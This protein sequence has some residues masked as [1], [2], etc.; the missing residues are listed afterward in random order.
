MVAGI[1][2]YLAATGLDVAQE[3]RKG[4]LVLSSAMDHLL[5]G[6]FD[7][8]RMLGMFARAVDQALSDGY[9]GLWGTGDMNWELGGEES[10]EKLLAYECGLELLLRSQPALSGICQYHQ[11]TLSEDSV[12]VALLTHRSVFINETLSRVNPFYARVESTLPQRLSTPGLKKMLAQLHVPA[13]SH[14]H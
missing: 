2:S 11:D 7:V 5:N 10:F 9:Q 3:V 8:E 13:S 12:H 6:R 4:S 14:P 1:R